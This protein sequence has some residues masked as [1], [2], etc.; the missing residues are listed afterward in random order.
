[1]SVQAGVLLHPAQERLRLELRGP[2]RR[3]PVFR[4]NFDALLAHGA[5]PVLLLRRRNA[6]G[7]GLAEAQ[8]F[9][10]L[11][12]HRHPHLAPAG[13]GPGAERGLVP[14]AAE[15]HQRRRRL[16]G[17]AG[18]ADEALRADDLLRQAGQEG[19]DLALYTYDVW[20]AQAAV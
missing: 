12:D 17:R 16:A 20:R 2:P 10:A 4:C 18:E 1:M 7:Q 5:L 9:E 6:R 14:P 15:L 19:L 8:P 3:R 11:P 13:P